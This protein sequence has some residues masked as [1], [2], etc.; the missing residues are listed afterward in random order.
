[1]AERPPSGTTAPWRGVFRGP[2]GRLTIGLLILE[3]LAAIHV[4][5]VATIMPKVLA[6]LGM[7][8]LYGLAF[9][10]SSLAT[11]GAIPIAAHALDRFGARRLLIVVLFLFAIGLLV[12]ATA[13]LMP[14]LLVGQFLVGAGS[15]GLYAISLGTVAKS[16]PDDL[17]ARV[18]ALLST[19]WILP[20]LLGPPL[21]AVIA[22]TVGWRWAFIAPFPVLVLAWILIAPALHLVPTA[23]SERRP[24]RV[25]WPIQVMVGAGLAFVAFTIVRWWSIVLLVGGIVVCLT[26]LVRIVPPGTLRARRGIAAISLEAFLLSCGFFAVDVFVTLTLTAIRGLSL[27]AAGAVLT[28]A[29]IAWSVGSAWQSGRVERVPL[30]RLVAIGGVLVLIGQVGLAAALRPGVP[31]FVALAGPIV[32]GLGMGVAFP[33]LPLAAMRTSAGGDEARQLSSVL[34]MD[35]LGTATGS[36]LAGGILAVAVA[37][38]ATLSTGLLVVFTAGI[39]VTLVLIVLAPRI[40]ANGDPVAVTDR[41]GI[42]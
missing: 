35:V 18:L 4:L 42:A 21:G 38:S 3:A 5:I 36:G 11:I 27:A 12:D 26:A 10:M 6:D 41:S 13:M 16:Y 1:M 32:T 30:S 37:R 31:L 17:R 20:G 9:T 22:D 19:M 40:A 15:G 34:L 8:Q 33:T 14:M 25:R 7:L 29:T 39:A 24:I 2:R 23:S 28:G